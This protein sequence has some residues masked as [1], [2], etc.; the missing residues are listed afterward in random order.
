MK[1]T[2]PTGPIPGV[3]RWEGTEYNGKTYHLPV[4]DTAAWIRLEPDPIAARGIV[5]SGA[6]RA[7]DPIVR[8]LNK[9]YEYRE[10]EIV[11]AP[12]SVGPVAIEARKAFEQPTGV[13][14][15]DMP[16]K[17]PGSEVRLPAAFTGFTPVLQQ[18][19]DFELAI[20]P[21]CYDEYYGYLTIDQGWIDN[22]ELLRE[23][24]CHVD[25]FQGARWEP[26]VRC[27]HS[28]TVSNC[29]P[30]LYYVQ[31]FDF[32]GLDPAVHDYFWEMNCQVADTNSAHIWRP[33]PWE[34]TLMDAYSVHRG[35]EASQPV[36]RTFL[37]L[38]FEARIFDRLGNAHNPL[39][40]YDWP[41]VIRDIE[42]LNLKP[43]RPD[44]DA[45]LICFPWQD[46]V[47]K[48]A[49]PA[50]TPKTKPNLYPK[51]RRAVPP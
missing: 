39:F 18:L 40:H 27:N 24:P 15:L 46:P 5:E 14:V 3:L 9:P 2:I 47:T 8:A 38:S 28:Y 6:I 36:F 43:F 31:P 7:D 25:G 45:S 4:F 26:K 35:D 21:S 11:R 29:V 10:F 50:G 23:A 32:R 49:L 44:A 34:I 13:R 19:L 37:R 22:D 16:I 1:K 20:N 48:Q 17:F 12:L 42:S 51:G 41:M 30:T 33:A